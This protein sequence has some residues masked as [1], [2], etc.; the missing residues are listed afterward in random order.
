MTKVP[1]SFFNKLDPEST[2]VP[3]VC[4]KKQKNLGDKDPMRNPLDVNCLLTQPFR[5][6]KSKFESSI[7]RTRFDSS[8][9]KVERLAQPFSP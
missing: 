4:K 8:P 7:F 5:T 6:M 3:V 2:R 9:Q 1:R